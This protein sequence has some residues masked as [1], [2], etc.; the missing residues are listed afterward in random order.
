MVMSYSTL[1]ADK[2]TPGSIKN[3]VGYKEIDSSTILDEAQSLIFQSLRTRE[4]RTTWTFGIEASG[5][6]IALPNRFLEPL[7]KLRDTTNDIR[8]TQIEGPVLE[9]QRAYESGLSGSYGASPFTTT[10]GS[11]IVIAGLTAHDLTEGSS[12]TN[13]GAAA[14][15][16]LDVNGTF[17][18]VEILD[19]NTFS[20]DCGDDQATSSITGG[21]SSATYTADKLVASTACRWAI[22]NEKLNLDVALSDDTRFRLPYVRSPALLSSTN[23]T[24]FLTVRYPK[25]IRVA[26]TAAAAEQMRDDQEFTKQYQQLVQIIQGINVENEMFMRGGDFETETP[27]PG[28]YY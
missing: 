7:G 13:A 10:A 23:E 4:M 18:V 19:A 11:S 24:N 14:V 2:G 3:W 9:D 20:F 26:T 21:G 16:G 28:D 25:L 27:T 22:F 6:S 17:P 5:C 15:G 1:L 8:L 12:V